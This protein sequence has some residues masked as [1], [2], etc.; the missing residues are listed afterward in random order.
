MINSAIL[1][2]L[3]HY[4][5]L[6]A[7]SRSRTHDIKKQTTFAKKKREK[8]SFQEKTPTNKINKISLSL[9][10]HFVGLL[11][12]FCVKSF[13]LSKNFGENVLKRGS[14]KT[15]NLLPFLTFVLSRLLSRAP[16][17]RELLPGKLTLLARK[18]TFSFIKIMFAPA[19]MMMRSNAAPTHR[20]THNQNKTHNFH[21]KRLPA[22]KGI[23]RQR[24]CRVPLVAMS[25][26][27]QGGNAQPRESY[28]LFSLFFSFSCILSIL[29]VRAI[30]SRRRFLDAA[31][32]TFS[33]SSLSTSGGKRFG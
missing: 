7:Q 30:V 12:S 23:R 3:L 17:Q 22:C 4:S 24:R 1:L 20:T 32:S 2:L 28:I 25:I 9:S 19:R 27:Q 13:F 6:N 33:L 29:S 10:L 8:H 26:P 16:R 14:Q 31:A 18:N 5:L 15:K 21:P 11:L